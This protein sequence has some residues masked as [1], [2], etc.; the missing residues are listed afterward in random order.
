MQW[1]VSTQ[2][3]LERGELGKLRDRDLQLLGEV[4][5][6]KDGETAAM[7]GLLRQTAEKSW[8]HS[9]G[10]V[11]LESFGVYVG[12]ETDARS[13]DIY[14][15]DIVPGLFQTAEYAA[16]LNRIFFPKDSED[17]Q[18]RR[19]QLGRQRQMILTRKAKPATVNLV[20]Q[21][22]VLRTVV[23][24]SSVMAAQLRHFAD[25]SVRPNITVR[26]LPFTAGFPLGITLGPFVI[27]DFAADPKGVA[28]PTV[29]Y[30]ENYTGDMY[31]EVE[32]DVRQY[33][34]ASAIIQHAALDAV[35]SRNL[36]RQVA[37]EYQREH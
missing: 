14:R 36:L 21:E 23:G 8:W 16:T 20:L 19:I 7:I 17:E 31:L 9:F 33:R 30:V 18:Q 5:G 26:V 10:D 35:T 32:T 4:L 11:I 13:L 34:R 29:I 2:S 37:K 6:F 15:P 1:S 25:M 12:L 22:A 24:G 3:R 28:A 27:L